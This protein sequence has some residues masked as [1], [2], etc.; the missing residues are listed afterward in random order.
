MR[1][2]SEL[3]E[4]L[5][6]LFDR[7]REDSELDEELAFHLEMQIE[8]NVRRG[9]TPEEARRQA[10]LKLGG[11]TQVR[12]AT[13]DA[14]GV[15]WLD[16]L[17]RD[18]RLA[19]RRLM[20][21]PG[22]T[23]PAV[24]TLALG[25][26]VTVAV[27]ALVDAVL[28]RPLPYTEP[29]RLVALHH[30]TL[31]ADQPM[32]GSSEALLH[33]YLDGSH[34]IDALGY[35]FDGVTT[36]T[37]LDAPEQVSHAMATPSV[38]EALG[39][40]PMLGRL[41]G[42]EDVS[43]GHRAGG[44][45]ISH[46]LWVR[47]YGADPDI[48]GRRIELE[49][50]AAPV[51]GVMPPGFHFPHR[52]T[53]LW[54]G[55]APMRSSRF[56]LENLWLS[57]VA[58]LRPGT[59]AADAERD[60][61]RL[62][63]LLP[64]A[65][66][67]VTRERLHSVGLRA[68]VVPL[69]DEVVGD[70]RP[71]LLLL[72]GTAAF[73]LLITGA[74]ATNLT[75][76]RA[77]RQRREVVV[78]R[79][80]GAGGVHVARRFLV[81]CLLVAGLGGAIGLALAYAGVTTRFGF[82]P[83]AIPRLDGVAMNGRVLGLAV[84]L[85]ALAAGLLG[86]VSTLGARRAELAGALSVAGGRVTAGRR[87]QAVRRVLVA[88]QVALALTLLIGSGLMARSFWRLSQVELGFEAGPALTFLP[89]LPINEYGDYQASARVSHEI[90][91]RVRELPGVE[92]IE[93]ASH[94][95]FP[96]SP[97][98]KYLNMRMAV[99]GREAPAGTARGAEWPSALYGFATPGYF[100]AMGIPLLSGRTF[101][102]GDMGTGGPTVVLSRSLARDLFG[103]EDPIGRQVH[104]TI[105]ANAH[106]YTVVGVVGDVPASSLHE[107]ATRTVYFPNIYPL[108]AEMADA[109][110]SHAPLA[111]T[112]VVRA[113]VPPATLLPAIRRAVADV[114][115]KLVMTRVGTL[116]DIV[117]DSMAETRL[118][119]LLLLIGAGTALLLGM[120]GI[121]G[122]LAYTVGRR[123]SELGIRIALGSTPA[124]V[125]RMIVAQGARIALAGAALG[126]VASL[127]LSRFLRG[128]LFEVAPNDLATFVA[129][130]ALLIA[131]AVVASWL[132]ARRAGRIDP[133][134][135]VKTE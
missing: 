41:P 132:P 130:T 18:L 28:L 30:H 32:T 102:S 21:E 68:R 8:E 37:D 20:R 27:F 96:L 11:V 99:P 103:T 109:P 119:M 31:S 66:P 78:A 48:I 16:D 38:F 129:M 5:R 63:A 128:L 73:L 22:Y 93:A 23:V 94:G 86:L 106:P 9:M 35:Y 118:T 121:H 49:R 112:Y 12:E 46:D 25:I 133:V 14:R 101:E 52:E 120:I 42:T 58:R 50:E 115:P 55:L 57:S 82:A 10:Q 79:A 3:R 75:L 54:I 135:A 127:G 114:D 53:Q 2:L 69:K 6:A 44:L 74:N 107:G 72:L 123:T 88:G 126:V 39:V 97:G 26:G 125:V 4:R 45:V 13:R 33:H 113:T 98:P 104:W 1:L 122:V 62:I 61:E 64:E 100:E 15:R 83:D 91:R 81:E 56:V 7:G 84:F 24:A 60:L 89:P 71:A 105:P 131:V 134:R 76:A 40:S 47:R 36:L 17:L 111:E 59:S 92:A 117:A 110:L 19:V 90:L 124:G 95:I 70:V 34:S 43:E 80:L 65:F 51:V 116:D 87:E 29:H 85:S 108:P 67:E 77:E